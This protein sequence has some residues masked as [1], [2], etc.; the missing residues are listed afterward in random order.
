MH[1]Y[2]LIVIRARMQGDHENFE[3]NWSFIGFF[4]FADPGV[5][6]LMW[7]FRLVSAKQMLKQQ[8]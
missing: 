8:F 7:E 2:A 3:E 5:G 1:P 6:R 4:V